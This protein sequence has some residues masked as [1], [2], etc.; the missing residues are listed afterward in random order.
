[1]VVIFL[2]GFAKVLGFFREMVIA[3]NF[4]TGWE[5]DTFLMA[6]II[7]CFVAEII[8]DAL[9][10]SIIPVLTE[11]KSKLGSSAVLVLLNKI[12][13]AV[14]FLSLLII[15]GCFY[16]A[17]P[18]IDLIAPGF[19]PSSR[20]LTVK[21][22]RILL[23]MLFFLNV[24]SIF[25]GFLQT[26]L[27]FTEPAIVTV[28]M[29]LC[30]LGCICLFSRSQGIYALAVGYTVG[31]AAQL[32]AVIPPAWKQ[33]YRMTISKPYFDSNLRKVGYLSIPV[34]IGLVVE[35]INPL[36]IRM[37]ASG[38][39]EGSISAL[40]YARM[41]KVFP[42]GVFLMALATV[43]YPTLS[44]N[45]VDQDMD[46]FRASL[47]RW[48]RL[49]LMFALPMTV[50]LIVLR[51][52]VVRLVYQRGSFDATSTVLTCIA[53]QY[54]AL[55]LPAVG[56]WELLSR[57]FYSLNDTRSPMISGIISVFI[58]I[59]LAIVLVKAMGHG[60]LALA[61]SISIT[62]TVLLLIY[63]LRKKGLYIIQTLQL[64]TFAKFLTA[65]CLMG[66]GVKNSYVYLGMKLNTFSYCAEVSCL[67]SIL[68]GVLLY[69]SLLYCFFLPHSNK[70]ICGKNPF[71]KRK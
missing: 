51:E 47:Q 12:L 3:N 46:K 7:P 21:L 68:I 38:L 29:N 48:L 9:G 28:P 33:G 37:L 62:F 17:H 32:L 10:T 44:A 56:I 16:S 23:P 36:V 61:S 20:L 55:G 59:F 41:L 66:L 71:F 31:T 49:L 64:V 24:V 45:V 13:F 25:V 1:M 53:L 58:N 50:G 2:T 42:Q 35:K 69:F 30:I 5:I 63:G 4:G 34:L 52:P 39:E 14:T 22:Y 6:Y 11:V 26:N 40:H 54:Y 57:A 67:V 70:Y 27:R 8:S 43:A 65:S 15:L 60:G 18:V 19:T